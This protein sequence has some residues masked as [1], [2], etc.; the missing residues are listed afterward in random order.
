MTAAIEG[1]SSKG[2]QGQAAP[3]SSNGARSGWNLYQVVAVGV[4]VSINKY[5]HRYMDSEEL[6]LCQTDSS[7]KYHILLQS[8]H[9][10]STFIKKSIAHTHTNIHG[11]IRENSMTN[12]F[13]VTILSVSLTEPKLHDNNTW[14]H[15]LMTDTYS[16]SDYHSHQEW[17]WQADMTPYWLHQLLTK[18]VNKYVIIHPKF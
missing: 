13:K 2:W 5:R 11:I 9:T 15:N 7:S 1:G 14:S 12:T 16:M 17:Q 3:R 8:P 10:H 6:Q 4:A 18:G